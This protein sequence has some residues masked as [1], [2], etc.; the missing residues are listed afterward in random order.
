[1]EDDIL[2]L[3]KWP[4]K[5][6]E[7]EGM[8][9]YALKNYQLIEAVLK[10]YLCKS[11]SDPMIDELEPLFTLEQVQYKPLG[12]L[13]KK[14]KTVNTNIQLH[15]QIEAAINDRNKISHHALISHH[16]VIAEMI[17]TEPLCLD[18]LRDVQARSSQLMT[19]LVCEYIKNRSY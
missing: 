14:F 17:G 1:M 7:N 2:E 9:L 8:V 5:L 11:K 3:M 13:F 4:R 16:P 10:S 15:K 12:W 6:H 19:D 18:E